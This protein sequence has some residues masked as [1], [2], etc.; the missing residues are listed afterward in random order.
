MSCGIE[1][2]AEKRGA[3]TVNIQGDRA[4]APD[5]IDKLGIRPMAA[6]L[7]E[8]LSLGTAANGLV[9]G[10][11]GQWGSGKTS[12]LNLTQGEIDKRPT[13]SRPLVIEF[14]PWLVGDRDSLLQSLFTELAA[15]LDTLES[16]AGNSTNRSIS[17]A[18]SAGSAVRE[19]AANLGGLGDAAKSVGLFI[20]WVG[21]I[22]LFLSGAAKA[23]GGK[24]APSLTK[25]KQKVCRRLSALPR[26]LIV[27]V[28]DLDRIDPKEIVE[29]LRLVRS[30]ADFPNVIYVL[31]YDPKIV[32]EAVEATASVSDGHAYMEKIVQI[33]VPVPKPEAFDL[34]RWFSGELKDL[35]LT[36]NAEEER[37]IAEIID[38]DGGRYLTTPRSVI[39][40]LDAIRFSQAALR[41]SVDLTDLVW[42]QLVKVG[43]PALYSWLETYLVEISARSTGR[44]SIAEEGISRSRKELDEALAQ[45]LGTFRSLCDRLAT[46]LPG[47]THYQSEGSD[48]PGIFETVG[49]DEID[50]AVIARRLAS[51]DHYRRFFTFAAPANVP[52]V[53][54]Y[55]ALAA[56]TGESVEATALLL[57][58]WQE[59]RLT[60][61]VSKTEVML[62]RLARDAETHL[63]SLEAA[64][65][66]RALANILDDLGRARINDLGGPDVWLRAT[67]LLPRL[68]TV[69]GED[70]N[71]LLIDV[72]STGRAIG[73]LTS[74][75]RA[76]TFAHG[77]A[78]DRPSS[79]RILSEA[80][81]D[82][83]SAIM[84]KRYQGMA[85][86][87]FA[88][89]PQPLSALF[90]WQQAGDPTGPK[91]LIEQESA[92]D[93]GLVFVLE[94]LSGLT[95]SSTVDGANEFLTL[96]RSNL[97]GMI[98]YD[99]ARGRIDEILARED[100]SE[101]LRRRAADVQ[102][103]FRAGEGF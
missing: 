59:Q 22:G 43:N 33:T 56:A 103:R 7:A 46:F 75:L 81:L 11:I 51:P 32:A 74:V 77:R 66:T 102:K 71:P 101:E 40:T 90:A 39:R 41:G 30:V 82:E 24:K 29:V 21:T 85:F 62:D 3:L 20:P 17:Q 34:R 73:W 91:S 69:V 1:A 57:T 100:V 96:S 63:T 16:Q 35:G 99:Y 45:E 26:P 98:D 58:A 67:R 84:I 86:A 92:T 15:G 9:V 12:L 48:A 89:L 76:E 36:A 65:F 50:R 23:A 61:G 27:V 4:L 47:I 10:V 94:T 95:R 31:G 64:T 83:I 38:L 2:G 8:A 19:F 37:R 6:R 70:R 55:N 78:G 97:T 93:E 5:G 14:K 79:D 42:L 80:E 72:F 68:L 49:R 60:S 13:D 52:L 44:V 87:Q 28:D 53:T 54:D 18:K 25:L 88:G